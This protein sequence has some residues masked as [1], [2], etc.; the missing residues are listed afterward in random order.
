MSADNETSTI[1]VKQ[2]VSASVQFV[3]NLYSD[4]VFGLQLEEVELSD[5]EQYWFVTVGF[6]R[7]DPNKTMAINPVNPFR[8]VEDKA[9][10]V[11]KVVK[12]D[13]LSGKPLSMKIRETAQAI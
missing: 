6:F 7:E 13:A 9:I 1:D 3:K 10:R 8:V 12:V 4:E 11:Y 2:A 5:D